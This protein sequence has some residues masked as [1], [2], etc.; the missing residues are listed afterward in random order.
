[1]KQVETR[2]CP[3]VHKII[4]SYYYDAFRDSLLTFSSSGGKICFFTRVLYKFTSF[5]KYLNNFYLHTKWQKKRGNEKGLLVLNKKKSM[6]AMSL[7]YSNRYNGTLRSLVL[8]FGLSLWISNVSLRHN[9]K[10][11]LALPIILKLFWLPTHF[12]QFMWFKMAVLFTF[13]GLYVYFLCVINDVPKCSKTL[14]K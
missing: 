4:Y 14:T 13:R 5:L 11:F 7:N 9:R 12:L 1:M 10:S 8:I 3:Y 2:R 6:S